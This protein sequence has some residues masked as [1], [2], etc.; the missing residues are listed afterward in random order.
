MLLAEDRE[1]N[2]EL[3]RTMLENCGDKVVVTRRR[4]AG[5]S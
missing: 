1:V 5:S 4:H 2:Q 3:P